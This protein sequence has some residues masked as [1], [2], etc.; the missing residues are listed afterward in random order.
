VAALARLGEALAELDVLRAL[1]EVAHRHNYSRPRFV[2]TPVIRIRDGR[3][4]LVEE[5][6]EFVPND[7]V[8]DEATHLAIVTGPNM[9]GKSVF[10]RQTALIALLAQIGSFVPAK[11]AELP[12][13]DRIYTRVGASDALAE[14]L[15]T[16]MAEM[17]EAATILSGATECSLVV[18]D[19]LGRGTG[20]HDGMALAWAIARSL[21]ERVRC[22]TLFATHYRELASLAEEIP[23]VVNLHVAV[24][25][26]QGEVVFL[27]RVRPGV[28]ERSYGVQVARLARLPSDVLGEAGRILV[29]LE[30][31]GP[32]LQREQLPLFG[33]E[34]H[35]VVA[36]LRRI[37][38]DGLTPREALELL[39][40]L[41]EL[42]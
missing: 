23:G 37:D 30:R 17:R 4:P 25:E 19:E 42:L 15:S 8:M 3:H 7:L 9:A 6:V 33:P 13:L 38:P 24:R 14:G 22:K 16:F 36:E 10:L 31:A 34:E 11:E 32:K 27:H 12:V 20:T 35:P 40:R 41:R 39:F 18:L 28:A 26:W 21:A 29:D 5:A 1:A 2:S